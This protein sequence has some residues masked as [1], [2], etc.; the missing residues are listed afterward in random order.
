[1]EG[2]Q[3]ALVLARE[4]PHP[5]SLVFALAFA[6]R[7][8]QCRHEEQAVYELAEAMIAISREQGLPYYLAQGMI[9]Q[10]WSL[11]MQGR[12]EEGIEQML[13]GLV[14]LRATGTELGQLGFLLQL[15]EGYRKT[16][17]TE[18]ALTVIDTSLELMDRN[19]VRCWEAEQYRLK[20]ELLLALSAEHRKRAEAYFLQALEVA[21]RQQARSLE[22]RAAFSLGQ[23]W[24]YQDKREEA[25]LLLTEVFGWFTE[26]FDT[27]DLQDVKAFLDLDV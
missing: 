16:G 1:L 13:Q 27:T 6:A 5:Y 8:H 21:R 7:L 25:K 15:A 22:L 9:L 24:Q 14:A 17:Q 18:K 26:G 12:G 2:S 3:H 10:G 4:A 23:L 19:G 20:G 11:T